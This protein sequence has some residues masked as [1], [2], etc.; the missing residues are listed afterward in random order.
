MKRKRSW[1]IFAVIAT[2]KYAE[3]NR[4]AV[5][6]IAITDPLGM[7]GERWYYQ[8]EM[9]SAA[10]VQRQLIFEGIGFEKAYKT[11]MAS[12]HKVTANDAP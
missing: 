5:D 11:I 9:T 3:V 10:K 2:V 4:G 1:I 6:Y 7:I 8:L 12:W